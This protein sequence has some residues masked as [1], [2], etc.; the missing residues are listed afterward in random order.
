MEDKLL[1]LEK[2]IKNEFYSDE[3]GKLVWKY[4]IKKVKEICIEIARKENL[5][6]N[7]LVAS[8]ILHDI[9]QKFGYENHAIKSAEMAKE[10]LKE[11]AFKEDF[12]K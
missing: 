1:T 9:G 5:D 8:A 7:I 10:I 4:H 3:I 2:R 11:M 12:I 6:E